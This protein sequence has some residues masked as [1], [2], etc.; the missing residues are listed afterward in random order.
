MGYLIAAILVTA[1]TTYTL[2]VL[3]LLLFKRPIQSIWI[4]S[5]LFYIPW[6][7]LTAM[8]IPAIFYATS[9]W[10]SASMGFLVAVLLAWYRQNLFTVALG[11]AVTTAIVEILINGM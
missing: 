6:A 10:V 7:V 2:R 9:S 8:T 3:P 4:Q 5:F 1:L 11:A